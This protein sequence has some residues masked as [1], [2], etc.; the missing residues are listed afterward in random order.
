MTMQILSADLFIEAMVFHQRIFCQKD[1]QSFSYAHRFGDVQFNFNNHTYDIID[2]FNFD[3]NETYDYTK[4]D[5]EYYWH[6]KNNKNLTYN[7]DKIIKELRI[8]NDIEN[9]LD[10]VEESVINSLYKIEDYLILLDMYQK[11]IVKYA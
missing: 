11:G 6:P 4:I 7:I 5:N 2:A 1:F 8:N 3:E 9:S 10:S